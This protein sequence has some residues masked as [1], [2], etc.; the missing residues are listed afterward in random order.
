MKKF[1]AML[2]TGT[3]ALSFYSTTALVQPADAA[4]AASLTADSFKDLQGIDASLKAKIDAMLAAQVFEGVSA[5]TFGIRDHM[6][7]AQFAKVAALIFDLSVDSSVTTSSFSDVQPTDA[8]N[9]WAIPYIEA[10]K[11]AGLIDGI[12]ETTFAPGEQVTAGQLD[13]I[14]LKGLGQ[15]VDTTGTPWFADA[16]KQA[17]AL[18]IHPTGKTG[19]A[20]ADRADLVASS[21]AVK[22]LVD[23]ETESPAAPADPPASPAPVSIVSVQ[24][25]SDN[26]KVQ[27][28]LDQEV[29]T[30]KATLTLTRGGAVVP[31]SAQWAAD[32]KS[33]TLTASAALAAGDY[34][35]TL[36]GLDASAVKR[37]TGSFTI[38]ATV[39]SGSGSYEIKQTLELANVIDSGLTEVASG[40]NGLETKANA[41]D[42]TV[43]K[44]A[45]EVKINVTSGGEA[46]AV[47]GIIKAITSSDPSIVKVGV[48]ADNR[49]YV[50][51]NKA[52]TATLNIMFKAL[53]GDDKLMQATVVVKADGVVGKIIRAGRTTYHHDLS[54]S[55][56][57]DAYE[58]M[59]L[60]IT[61][62][63]DIKYEKSEIKKYNFAL[64]VGFTATA[65]EGGGSVEVG[66]DGIV[67][68]SG[69][70]TSFELGA[71]LPSGESAVT[72]VRVE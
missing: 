50:L 1:V 49:G 17:A 71:V 37:A 69:T 20:A 60:S 8:A 56:Q 9:G 45:K 27:V 6:T 43:S 66:Q 61:D 12:T 19:D 23:K 34:T 28:A 4:S 47:P 46:V 5:D 53:D 24:A 21:Y 10:A 64:A 41:E 62:N 67:R 13:T 7:R 33:A 51:G 42:P 25:S 30:A 63:Y 68:I 18:G 44:F 2:A 52:G 54:A 57:F 15:Q 32:K 65:I 59:D 55:S 70:V 11:K 22:K 36:T 16:V 14:L 48:S 39:S 35:V 31:A 38:K 26:A 72:Y 40:S 58:A 29:D 3:L